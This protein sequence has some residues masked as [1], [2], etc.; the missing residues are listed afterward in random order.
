MNADLGNGWTLVAPEETEGFH[1]TVAMVSAYFSLLEHNLVL[2]LPFLGFDPSKRDLKSFIG[3][4]WGMK[5]KRVF[6]VD[7]NNPAKAH[8]DA[9]H[10]IAEEYRNTYGHGGFDKFGS[11]ILFHMEGVGA[12]PAVLSDIRDRPYFSFTPIDVDDF[13][14][15]KEIFDA[16]DDWVN[17]TA[18]QLAMKWIKGGLDVYYDDHFR[19]QVKEAMRSED[20][21]MEMLEY[22]VYKVD[23]AADMGW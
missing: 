6:P 10:R 22:H 20:D 14:G 15:I 11:S 19:A 8:F 9:L 13:E 16:F 3:D 12:L 17:E 23:Q 1:N 2:L 18:A 5:F 21:F 7:S 4:R